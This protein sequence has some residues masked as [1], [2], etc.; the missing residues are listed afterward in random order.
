M[1]KHFLQSPIATVCPPRV[2][3]NSAT[4]DGKENQNSLILNAEVNEMVGVS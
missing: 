3:S 1:A 4:A 2:R